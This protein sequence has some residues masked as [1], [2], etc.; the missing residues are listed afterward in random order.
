MRKVLKYVINQNDIPILFS[1]DILHSDILQEAKS[2]GFLS[3]KFVGKKR[4]YVV[5][6]FGESTSLNLKSDVKHDEVII[7]KL[8]NE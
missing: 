3:V 6:C 8:F 1:T 5:K 2:A 7:E 4:K